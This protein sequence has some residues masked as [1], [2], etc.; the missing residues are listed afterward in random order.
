MADAAQTPEDIK[1]EQIGVKK[2]MQKFTAKASKAKSELMHRLRADPKFKAKQHEGLRKLY[3]NP[4]YIAECSERMRKLHT[5]P[6]FKARLQDRMRKQMLKWHADPAFAARNSA[7]MR[8]R[9]ADPKFK[10]NHRKRTREMHANPEFKEWHRK[11]VSEGIRKKRADPAHEAKR[12]ATQ[13]GLKGVQIPLW[14]P[15]DLWDDFI[16]VALQSDEIEAARHVRRLKHEGR[17]PT[18]LDNPPLTII[19]LTS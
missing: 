11:R 5:N 17:A 12:A 3:E 16:D 7:R 10:A 9:H 15:R 18:P 13:A 4:A 19:P 14:V 8:M 2:Q 6:E 1:G